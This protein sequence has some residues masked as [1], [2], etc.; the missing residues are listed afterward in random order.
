MVSAGIITVHAPAAAKDPNKRFS[1]AV[2]ARPAIAMNAALNC[3][4]NIQ[5]RAYDGIF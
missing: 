3:W 1:K 4:K 2:P 5:V